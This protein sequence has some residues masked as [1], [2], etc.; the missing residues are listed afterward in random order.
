MQSLN[1]PVRLGAAILWMAALL[2]PAASVPAP[3]WG[4]QPDS[5]AGVTIQ[6]RQ[7]QAEGDEV[8][9]PYVTTPPAVVDAMLSMAGVTEGD[10]VYDLGSGDG[11]IPITAATEY[12]A[13][14]V[15]IEIKP[16]LVD[17]ARAHA[18]EAGVADRVEFRR[19]DFFETDISEATVVTL[20]LLPEVNLK[21]RAKLFRELAPGTWVVSHGFDMKR[22]TPLSTREVRGRRLYLWR[23]PEEPPDFVDQQ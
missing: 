8:A 22:W 10:V 17:T 21:L 2:V 16:A 14:G 9:V 13:R 7:P 12:G 6:D 19:Q 1:P 15:G 4:Q 18:R 23:I 11:R 20:Y 5:A 3:C